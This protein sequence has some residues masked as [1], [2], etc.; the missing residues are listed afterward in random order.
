[1]GGAVR[2]C[3]AHLLHFVEVEGGG[4]GL[5][6]REHDARA[7][8]EAERECANGRA[9]GGGGCGAVVSVLPS[10][11]REHRPRELV[12]NWSTPPIR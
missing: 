6:H 9:R 5:R 8:F 3:T 11:H 1:M 12:A 2:P 10:G 7:V 4:D